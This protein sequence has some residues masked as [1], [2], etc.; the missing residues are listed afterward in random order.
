MSES[1]N[2]DFTRPCF[3]VRLS[4]T[5]VGRHA[6]HRALDEVRA[7]R[8]VKRSIFT[9]DVYLACFMTFAWLA[10][11]RSMVQTHSFCTGRTVWE[12]EMK[13]SGNE[14]ALS[15][16]TARSRAPWVAAPLLMIAAASAPAFAQP[17]EGEEF[18]QSLVRPP[19]RDPRDG[20]PLIANKLFPLQN[21]WEINGA[22]D[23]TY[24]NKYTEHYGGHGGVGYHLFDWLSFHAYGG[25]LASDLTK[26]AEKVFQV[27]RSSTNAASAPELC[28]TAAC[29][30][31]L[32]DLWQTTWFAGAEAQWA[33]IYGKLSVVS[34]ADMSF[35]L[36]GSLGGGAEGT[37][38]RLRD[39]TTE[40]GQVRPV[41]SYGLGLRLL[42]WRFLALRVE[43]RNTLGL[44]PAV[45]ERN[46]QGID[47][48]EEGYVLQ[49]GQQPK[50]Q[51]DYSNNALLQLG[52]SFLL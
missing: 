2:V 41:L 11:A 17:A 19:N 45:A 3:A 40:Q 33:P 5:S 16:T 12:V 42:P 30:P 43:L 4:S 29:E 50:C 44:N 22:F 13:S 31:E 9:G 7:R 27:G 34:E 38:R 26:I 24:G 20:T 48:C 15:T 39:Q 8:V 46:S 18:E 1:T 47:P 21:R 32:P 51:P 49:V 6:R 52:L 10:S 25:Y 37:Q 36:Y 28:A 35:Q 23:M 14:R